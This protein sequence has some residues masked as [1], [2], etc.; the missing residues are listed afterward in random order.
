MRVPLSCCPA[1]QSMRSR[2]RLKASQRLWSAEWAS[3][4]RCCSSHTARSSLWVGEGA[5]APFPCPAGRLLGQWLLARCE[6]GCRGGKILAPRAGRSRMQCFELHGA[7]LGLLLITDVP[8]APWEVGIWFPAV[9][10]GGGCSYPGPT[11]ACRLS[12]L[13][14]IPGVLPSKGRL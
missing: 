7:I 12:L 9:H 14:S 1:S 6:Q 4:S 8:G 13:G 10:P 3:Q 11:P 5:P 2:R